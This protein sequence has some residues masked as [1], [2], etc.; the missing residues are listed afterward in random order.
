[1]TLRFCH[2]R[3]RRR[4]IGMI[5]L[6]ECRSLVEPPLPPNAQAMSPPSVYTTWWAL[7]EACSGF[8]GS[9]DRVRW[10]E[11]PNVA[12]IPY[13]GEQQGVAYWS[14]AGNQIVSAGQAVLD[15]GSVRHDKETKRH[16]FD[17]LPSATR[18]KILIACSPCVRANIAP[19]AAKRRDHAAH[20]RPESGA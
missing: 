16:A 4:L 18:Y 6:A 13:L 1:M 17:F 9:L 8:H 14:L 5:L 19:A 3:D 2:R 10:Y 12:T 11:V 20:V 7:T 15:G